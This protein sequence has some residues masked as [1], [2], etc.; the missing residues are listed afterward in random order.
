MHRA[1]P[2]TLP[3]THDARGVAVMD[4]LKPDIEQ[5]VYCD[6][7]HEMCVNAIMRAQQNGTYQP[8]TPAQIECGEEG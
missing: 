5:L 4:Q 3:H 6:E 1:V 8:T 7:L 2:L